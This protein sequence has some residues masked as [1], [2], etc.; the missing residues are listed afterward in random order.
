M[1]PVTYVQATTAFATS[2]VTQPQQ[3][4][5]YTPPTT[6]QQFTSISSIA[7]PAVVVA[8]TAANTEA[9]A[10]GAF[11]TVNQPPSMAVSLVHDYSSLIS[12]IIVISIFIHALFNI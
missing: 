11:V 7:T 1:L 12:R 2:T 10:G 9:G 6:T 8:T 5:T 3:T 4:V